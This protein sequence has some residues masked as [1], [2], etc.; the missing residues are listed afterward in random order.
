MR[1][2]CMLLPT[3]QMHQHATKLPSPIYMLSIIN[4]QLS[5]AVNISIRVWCVIHLLWGG[6]VDFLY[7][8][9]SGNFELAIRPADEERVVGSHCDK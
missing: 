8:R 3:E 2:T 9:P 6:L 5:I 7:I 1:L 4:L